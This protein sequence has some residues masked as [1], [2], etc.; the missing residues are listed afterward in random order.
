V[1]KVVP[2]LLEDV[3]GLLTRSSLRK[4]E[5]NVL[6]PDTCERKVE[7]WLLCGRWGLAG[8][9]LPDVVE[10]DIQIPC[11]ST[12]QQVLVFNMELFF[13]RYMVLAIVEKVLDKSTTQAGRTVTRSNFAATI[14]NVHARATSTDVGGKPLHRSSVET[15]PLCLRSKLTGLK[16][17]IRR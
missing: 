7:L 3:S 12:E 2:N 15:T 17:L 9:K 6:H 14:K 5:E 1:Q 16:R 11:P 10:R 4:S 13:I 8:E